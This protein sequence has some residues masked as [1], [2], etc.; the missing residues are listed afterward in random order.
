MKAKTNL[1][2]D[3]GGGIMMWELSQDV[4]D[5]R[6]LTS[7]IHEVVVSRGGGGNGCVPVSAS[8][9]DGNI[10]S[11]VLDGNLS[12]RWSA[13][14]DGQWIQFC[15]GSTVSV[16]G[17][18][19]AFYSGN[20]RTSSFDV[21]VSADGS[22][23]TNAATGLVSSGTSLD[24]QTFT[25]ATPK[26]AQYVRIVGHGN[27]VN[28]WNS[29]TEVKINSGTISAPIGQTI[30]LKGN[31][32]Q[33]VSSKGNVEPMQ[34]NATIAQGWNQFL[35]VDAGAG[36]IALQNQGLYVSSEN[37][38]QA[39]NCNR[40]TVQDWEKFDWIV[41][42]DGTISLRG[43]NGMY[44]SSENGTVPMNCNR[45][46]IQGW[47][48]FNY[49]VVTAAAKTAETE[50]LKSY[51]NPVID[52]LTYTVPEGTAT[53]NVVVRDF[54]GNSVLNLSVGEVAGE[55]TIDTSNWTKGTY[56]IKVFNS[57]FARTFTIMKE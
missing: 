22:S 48:V 39:M 1:A 15:L 8:A 19:I 51:P 52:R 36:K 32:A 55:N 25:F 44:V 24:L 45:A 42:T 54:T 53:H 21:Q 46:T 29:Y 4:K 10:P 34:C 6:S 5:A 40:A 9:D 23:W 28:T 17:V 18:Q 30:W 47:E 37:G 49:G 2:F 56:Y 13:D 27:S 11:N 43:N 3:Q 12:T 31:N 26:I 7:A 35:V 20:V 16:T 14:G 50:T 38:E 41:N 57:N 33:Y